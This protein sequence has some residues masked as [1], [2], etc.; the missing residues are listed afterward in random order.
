MMREQDASPPRLLMVTTV[1]EMLYSFLLPFARH[2]R[3][4]GWRVD[5]LARGVDGWPECAEAFD[6]VFDI[7]W[8]RQ[9][10]HPTNLLSVP[11]RVRAL[12]ASQ[13]YDLVHVHSP[14]AAFVTRMALRRMRSTGKPRVIYTAHGFH[15]Y[16]GGPRVRGAMFR[17]LE[18]L[19][20]RWTDYLVVINREDEEAALRYG[21][22]PPDRLR[23]MPG[24]GVDTQVYSAAAVPPSAIAAVRAELELKPNQSLFLMVAEFIPR[25]RHRDVLHAFA[26]L[27]RP[28]AVLALASVGPL[29]DQMKQLATSL[30]IVDR[31]RFL[32]FR[33]D[34]PALVQSSVATLLPSEQE[35]LPRTVMESMCQSV[36]VIASCIRGVT[37]LLRNG[38]GLMVPVGDVP[39]LTNALAWVLDHPDEAQAMG[40]RGRAVMA[41]YDLSHILELHEDLYDEALGGVASRSP[42]ELRV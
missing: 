18:R 17:T 32:G 34:V 16:H 42:C 29:L 40:E 7:P 19:A 22:V 27:G 41:A 11:K 35:G 26:R 39:A 30:G 2:F 5:A 4:R 25:K 10:I 6:R 8:S 38:R 12:V 3:A 9:P 1:A 15:F 36:P 21:I 24:I 37:D 33:K 13:G 14:V 31:V 20:G 28:N 23:Y